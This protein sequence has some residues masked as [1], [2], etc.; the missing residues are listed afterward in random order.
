M[1]T[2][3]THKNSGC[4]RVAAAF[5]WGFYLFL[6]APLAFS[7][8]PDETITVG[9]VGDN[10]PYSFDDGPG[11]SGFSVDV[12]REV[13]RQSGLNFRFRAGTWPANHDGILRG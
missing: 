9:I 7:E 1:K 8:Q 4:W 13:A 3:A 6:T 5:L 2:R 11:A 12:L 10:K